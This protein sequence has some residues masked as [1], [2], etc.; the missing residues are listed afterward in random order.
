M[1]EKII[2][3]GSI[4]DLH[5]HTCACPKG[6]SEFSR[7]SVHD[8]ID[9]LMEIFEKYPKLRLISFTDHNKISKEVYDE[10]KGRKSNINFVVGIE[11]D[12]NLNKNDKNYKHLIF[13]FDPE[14]FNFDEHA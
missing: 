5:I 3:E 1:E 14:K 12:I 8:Y 10:F 7:L 11:V 6:S 13:Y 2:N 4:W 9:K